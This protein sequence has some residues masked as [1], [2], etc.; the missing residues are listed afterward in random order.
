MQTGSLL[1]KIT[2]F[3]NIELYNRIDEN[4]TLLC[5]WDEKQPICHNDASYHNV[6]FLYACNICS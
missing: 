5:V 2:K 3:I 1:K 4:Q 6:Y